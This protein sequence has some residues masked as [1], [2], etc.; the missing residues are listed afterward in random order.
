MIN[1]TL[2]HDERGTYRAV[3]GVMSTFPQA[4]GTIARTVL[5]PVGTVPI[6]RQFAGTI[7]S[8]GVMV[9]GTGTSFFSDGLKVGDYIY[10]G[11]SA[12]R[13]IKAIIS[14]DLLELEAAFPSDLSGDDL[15]VCERQT[16]KM[17]SWVNVGTGICILQ[18]VLLGVGERG[19]N[20]GAP[21][22]YDASASN[23]QI[24]FTVSQ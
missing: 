8:T 6:A 11:V 2:W 19:L 22:A 4:D 23:G 3:T 15:R 7:T 21:V 1:E 10:D 12:L 24:A 13:M 17:I 20:G 5:P 18:E 14:E 9:R 16:F